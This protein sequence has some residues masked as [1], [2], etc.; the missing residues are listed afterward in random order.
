VYASDLLETILSHLSTR[1]M[2]VIANGNGLQHLNLLLEFLAAW[3]NRPVYLTPMTYQWCSAISKAAGRLGVGKALAN[4]PPSLPEIESQLQSKDLCQDCHYLQPHP[5]PRPQDLV[6]SDFPSGAKYLSWKTEREF[7]HVGP[8][9]DPVHMDD[10]SCHTCGCPQN[11]ISLHRVMLLP[12]ILEIGFHLAGPGHQSILYLNYT[13]HHA[14]ALEV[15]FSSNNDEVIADAVNVWIVDSNHTPP[16]YFASY[17]AK[18]VESSRPFSPRLRQVLICAIGPIWNRNPEVLGLESVCLLNRLNIGIEDVV[19]KEVWGTPLA[20]MIC[21]PTGLESLSTHYWCLL[22]KL[23]VG[24]DFLRS[25][26]LRSVE[27]MRSLKEAEDWEKLEIWM[28]VVWQSLSS[29]TPTPMME[30][31]ERVTLKLFSRRPSAPQKFE[32]LYEQG[33]LLSRYKHNLRWICDQPQVKKLPSE[34]PLP[35]YVSVCP[36]RPPILMHPYLC[37]SQSIH[38]QPLVPLPFAGDDTF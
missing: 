5:R 20:A 3:E 33:S 6:N 13:S 21:L 34:T 26:G 32:T 16:G 25:P 14:W 38:A 19:E 18:R 27:V 37:F 35:P 36:Q 31:I 17:F 12:I 29:S 24:T 7:F 2:N 30:D 11:M 22:D 4:P 9:C 15:A 10:A 1:V 23:A 8:D 28:V